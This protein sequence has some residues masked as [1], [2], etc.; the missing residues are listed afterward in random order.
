MLSLQNSTLVFTRNLQL[1][2]IC[3]QR[4]I[5]L[6]AKQYIINN[7]IHEQNNDIRGVG[8]IVYRHHLLVD[9]MKIP[10]YVI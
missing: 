9:M 6:T 4:A 2:F 8:G 10:V 7:T 3:L 5:A 1:N